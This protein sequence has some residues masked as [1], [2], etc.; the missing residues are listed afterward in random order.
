MKISTLKQ[1]AGWFLGTIAIAGLTTSCNH[2]MPPQTTAPNAP[3]APAMAPTDHSQMGGMNHSAMDSGPADADYDLRFMDGM[4]PHH[5][6]AIV[7]AQA[8]MQQS[9]RPELK[10]LAESVIRSQTQETTKMQQWRS[11]WYPKAA[12]TPMAWSPAMKHMMPMSAEQIKSMRMDVDLGKADA[13][14]DRR[15]LD[16]MIPHHEGAIVMAQDALKK[17]KRP[18]VQKLAKEMIAAQQVEIDQMKQWRKAWY[19]K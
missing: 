5:D 4:T 11:T 15:F 2:T 14:F 13:D 16:A 9:Q 10:K 19:G 17:T 8:V 1:T 7:M 3:T 12:A 6:G 18:E